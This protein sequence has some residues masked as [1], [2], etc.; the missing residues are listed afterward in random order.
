MLGHWHFVRTLPCLDIVDENHAGVA[1]FRDRFS[2][3]QVYFQPGREPC[4][5]FIAAAGASANLLKNNVP[6]YLSN[7][8]MTQLKRLG[9]I[10]KPEVPFPGGSVDGSLK[11]L[12]EGLNLPAKTTTA[13]PLP[14]TQPP[15]FPKVSPRQL[16]SVQATTSLHKTISPTKAPYIT[17]KGDPFVN[18][19]NKGGQ[20]TTS[21]GGHTH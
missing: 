17:S 9:S 1:H 16:L 7:T 12:T 19:T 4:Q 8:S 6:N 11:H 5:S 14:D 3:T 15:N 10:L 13:L 2:Q 18:A 21:K 20:S